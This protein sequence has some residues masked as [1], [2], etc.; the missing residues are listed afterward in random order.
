MT[1]LE[2]LMHAKAYMEKLAQGINPLDDS[3]IPDN[4]VV[5]NVRLSRCFFYVADVLRQVIDNGGITKQPK[6]KK[7]PFY[8][9]TEQRESFAFSEDP[10]TISEVA[11]RINDLI[12]MDIM[13]RFS[14]TTLIEWLLSI[15]LIKKELNENGTYLKKP[16]T[17]GE[18]LGITLENRMGSSGPYHV[19]V[20][21]VDAQHFIIDNIDSVIDFEK[22][23][24]ENQWKPWTTEQDQHLF[25]LYQKDAS[26]EEIANIMKRNG[27]AIRSRLRKLGAFH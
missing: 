9:T 6:G 5:N 24:K 4:D 10:L 22:I 18:R 14:R 16:T 2:S 25:V 17:E 7:L 21:N 15:G 23:G 8:L 26:I 27:G 13:V 20:Y 1:E 3:V 12:A 19:I 11:N